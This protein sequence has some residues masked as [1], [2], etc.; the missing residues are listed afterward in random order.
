MPASSPFRPSRRRAAA[1]TVGL[2]VLAVA[3]QWAMWP[4]LASRT[5][6]FFSF[7]LAAVGIIATWFGW[8]PALIVLVVGFINAML[9]LQSRGLGM[10]NTDDG[11][12]I[13]LYV[14]AAAVLLAVGG[15]LHRL[16][17]REQDLST[18]VEDLQALQE[19]G[20]RVALLP[21]LK[22][23]LTA[24][25]Q[26]L[27]ELQGA[28]KGLVSLCDV[29]SGTLRAAAILG[30]SPEG[31]SALSAL[32]VGQGAGGVAF[33][34]QRVV[35]VDDIE[36]DAKF[37]EFRELGRQEGFRCIHSRPM[38]NRAGDV[39]G[40][41]SIYFPQAKE[42][43]ARDDQLGDLLLPDG[44]GAHRARSAAPERH[45]LVAA[46]RGGAGKLRRCVLPVQADTRRGGD[47]R[48]L[49]LGVPQ[50]RRRAPAGP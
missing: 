8:R 31:E 5:F 39:F 1:I 45:S 46:S 24:I 10:E 19:L 22:G 16:Q 13:G 35:V 44:V 12:S 42:R 33:L 2:L 25:L 9:W 27:C 47:G 28:Q 11:V 15:R 23:Q 36:Q 41:I 48:R 21:D 32:P 4:L 3:L 49:V 38:F 37:A 43:T 7:F 30:F 26:S 29:D 50:Q 34:E 6:P 14:A 17:L 20:S 40:V 18:Q